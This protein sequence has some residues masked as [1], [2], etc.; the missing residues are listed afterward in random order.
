MGKL[1]ESSQTKPNTASI[2]TWTSA[3]QKCMAICT[4]LW[5]LTQLW[6]CVNS[7]RCSDKNW[8][9]MNSCLL[10][11]AWIVSRKK[12]RKYRKITVAAS[13]ILESLLVS[14]K[15]HR[16]IF[17]T[18]GILKKTLKGNSPAC[19][20]PFSQSPAA[21]HAGKAGIAA[22]AVFTDAVFQFSAIQLC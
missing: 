21:L 7:E 1:S 13:G 17:N 6:T 20:S 11:C 5:T 10:S 3:V 12:K 19:N 2:F 4:L 16:K 8:A 18:N 15:T 9:W 14:L 22:E